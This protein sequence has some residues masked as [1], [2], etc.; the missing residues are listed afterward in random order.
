MKEWDKGE[1]APNIRKEVEAAWSK[2]SKN[3]K[4]K[5]TPKANGS[6]RMWKLESW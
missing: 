2:L 6:A 5:N 1:H 4:Q 3:A